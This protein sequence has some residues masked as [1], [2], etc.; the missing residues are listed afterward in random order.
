MESKQS[1]KTPVRA[2]QIVIRIIICL[3]V[4]LFGL[5][6]MNKLSALKKP[7]AEAKRTEQALQVEGTIVKTEDVR[8]ILTGYGEIKTLNTVSISPEISGRVVDVHPRLDAGEIIPRGAT[9]FK[10]DS[11]IYAA[12]LQEANASLQQ[13][14]NTVLRL[15][16]QLSLDRKRQKTIGRNRDLAQLEFKRIQQLYEVNDVGTRSSVDR[17][18]QA[19]N[20]TVDQADLMARTLALYPLQIQEVNSGIEAAKARFAIAEV[21]LLR[22]RVTSPFTGRI[23]NASVEIGQFVT[24]GQP[25]VTLADDTLLE[26]QI[27]LAAEDARQ[28]LLFDHNQSE[29]QTTWFSKPTPVACK[30]RWTENPETD[31]WTGIL[32]KVVQFNPQ[33]RTLTVAIHIDAKNVQTREHSLFPLV[34][35]MF[36]IVDVPGKTIQNVVRLPRWSVSFENTVYLATEESRLKTIPVKVIYAEGE[37]VFVSEGL[38]PGQTVVTTRLSD[39]LENALLAVTVK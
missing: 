23:K 24:P 35:G 30:L 25:L 33:T 8:V 29:N 4:L 31:P 12:T 11:R 10:I 37:N 15:E 32:D 1:I 36:C 34:E 18:E 6:I 19:Y 38:T 9:L 7:P 13:L 22:C 2:R 17:T 16:K 3:I 26:I 21:N 20:A 14:K 39:P 5:L 28:W 27:S